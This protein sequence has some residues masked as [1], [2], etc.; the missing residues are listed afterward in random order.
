S[1]SY[2]LFRAKGSKLSWDGKG[3][4]DLGGPVGV[5]TGYSIGGD[6]KDKGIAVEEAQNS[7][8]NFTKLSLGR[9][10]A[11]ATLDVT[12]DDLLATGA[13]PTIEKVTPPLVTKDYF[14]M[15][16]HQFYAEKPELAEKLWAKIA[17]LREA[18]GAELGRKYAE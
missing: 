9:V 12:G 8:I 11:V 18:K 6:L 2:S 16:S 17:Q 14:V 4:G 13:F 10:G 7:K 3:I 1:V 15:V 5:P